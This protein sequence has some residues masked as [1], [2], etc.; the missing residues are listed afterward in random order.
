[1]AMELR[2]AL[3]NAGWSC[4]S[5]TPDPNATRGLMILSP[6]PSKGAG[7]LLNWAVNNGLPAEL[8]QAPR[9]PRLRILVGHEK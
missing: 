2:Q 7:T 9:M 1:M 3:E 5:M 4:A 6:H 8:R